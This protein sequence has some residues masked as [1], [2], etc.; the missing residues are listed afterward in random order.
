MTS[1]DLDAALRSFNELLDIDSE[2]LEQELRHDRVW[3]GN[4]TSAACAAPT[5]CRATS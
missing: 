5:S 2:S 1:A 4:A 3:P